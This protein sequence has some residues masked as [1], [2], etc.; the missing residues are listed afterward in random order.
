ML[1]GGGDDDGGCGVESGGSP[2]GIGRPGS[3]EGERREIGVNCIISF[4]CG[5]YGR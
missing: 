4:G 1:C 2:E 5:V 3:P